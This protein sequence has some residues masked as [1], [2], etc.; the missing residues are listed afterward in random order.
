VISRTG[1]A[2][3]VFFGLAGAFPSAVNWGGHFWGFLPLPLPLLLGALMAA[4]LLPVVQDRILALLSRTVKMFS[5]LTPLRRRILWTVLCAGVGLILWSFRQ[6]TFFLGDGYLILRTLPVAVAS[7]DIPA[8]FPTAPLAGYLAAGLFGLFRAAGAADPAL[9]AWQS[10]SVL[11]GVI[12]LPASWWL[13]RSLAADARERIALTALVYAGGAMMLFFGYVETYAPAYALLIAFVAAALDVRMRNGSLITFLALFV[14]LVFLHV[15]MAILGALVLYVCAGVI[16]AKGWK[17]LLIPVL[18]AAT[19]WA[20]ALL[21]L[22]YSPQRIMATFLRDGASFLPIGS[23]DGWNASYTLFSLWHWVDLLNLHILLAPFSLVLAGG[24]FAGAFLPARYRPRE[25]FF[26]IVLAAPTLL[27]LFLNNF[28]LGMS[29]DW[30]LAAPFAAMVGLGGLASWLAMM[31]PSETRTRGVVLM[32]VMTIAHTAGWVG[33][34]AGVDGSLLR[35]DALLDF[36][37]IPPRA[38]AIAYEEVGDYRRARGDLSGAAEAFARCVALDSA[39]ARRWTVLGN[40]HAMQ[41]NAPG[42]RLAYE[43]A[44]ALGSTDEEVRMNLGIMLFRQ[45]D[46]DAA[47]RRLQEAVALDSTDANASCTLGQMLVEGKGDM[48]GALP[49]FERALRLDPGNRKARAYADR[50]RSVLGPSMKPE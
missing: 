17:P 49:W 15:G 34:N 8:S 7:G 42:A 31:G 32:A 9:Y 16:R 23:T 35:Y 43:R 19:A 14:A 3:L 26:W 2:L 50:C 48:R 28:E 11:S 37:S 33:V 24:L 22:W 20:I 36:R 18:A 25:A 46:T 5:S 27:W 6:R 30:D 1:L 47:V 39:N 41:G 10:L 12:A 13:A 44:I 4:A 21:L 29:R 38:M 40:T 45:G